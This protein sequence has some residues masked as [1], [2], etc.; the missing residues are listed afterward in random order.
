MLIREFLQSPAGKVVAAIVAVLGL[1]M[2]F[3]AIRDVT[4]DSHA[5]A[6]ASRMFICSETGKP[7]EHELTLGEKQPV[8]SPFTDKATGYLAEACSWT[9]DGKVK[10]TP[11]WVL[12]NHW[13]GKAGPTY[14]TDCDRLVVQ[15]N[16]IADASDTP[17]PTSRE[18]QIDVSR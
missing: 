17:P 15:F 14:C 13:I 3:F 6:S 12:M 5:R 10:S 2:V 9:A 4:L 18:N 11:T 7:F 1:G 16:P 8:Q